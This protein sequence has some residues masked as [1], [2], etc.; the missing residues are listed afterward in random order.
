M[1]E[2]RSPVVQNPGF[3]TRYRLRSKGD[4]KTPGYFVERIKRA[5]ALW[6]GGGSAIAFFYQKLK[7][8]ALQLFA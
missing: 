1:I 3:C 8:I 4:R 7:I 5:I 6:D 2:V